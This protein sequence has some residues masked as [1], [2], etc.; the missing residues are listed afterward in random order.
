[1]N[2]L[3]RAMDTKR[4]PWL[5][6][7]AAAFVVCVVAALSP[8]IW[9]AVTGGVGLLVL[10]SLLLVGFALVQAL[11]LLGQ[12]LENTLL[13]A[14][15]AEARRNPIE[16][17]ENEVLR[18]G[19]RLSAFRKALVTV[20]GQIESIREMLEDSY[21]K[22][23][24]HSLERQERA[25]EKLQQFHQLNLNRLGQ[26]HAALKEFQ[27]VVKQKKQEW[28][29]GLAISDTSE[30]LDPHAS[31]NLLQDLL[32]DTAL[33]TVQDRFNSVFAE[34]DV[35]MSSVGGPTRTLLPDSDLD[36]LDSLEIS[37]PIRKRTIA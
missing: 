7:L 4:V 14:R 11:P 23:P 27:A 16:Q 17:L 28:I 15:K 25:L 30:A 6:G 13:A 35:Q 37:Q 32:T 8:L 20:G 36:H 24:G 31:E 18:R 5:R 9:L 3:N 29:I 1:M 26:A 10:G 22:S 33:R 19:E 2:S 12:K 21:R 34:L